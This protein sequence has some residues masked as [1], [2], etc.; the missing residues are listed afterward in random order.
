MGAHFRRGQLGYTIIE[1][2]LFFAVTGA[3]MLGVLGSASFGVNTQRY[4]DAVNTFTAIIQQEFTNVTNVTNARSIESMC[5]PGGANER[6]RGISNCV[7]I[8]RLMTVDTEGDIVSTNIVGSDPG[9]E[10]ETD[11]EIEVIQGYSPKVDVSSQE[12]DKMSWETKLERGNPLAETAASILILRSPRS[13][14]VYSYVIHSDSEIITNDSQL[15]DRISELATASPAVNSVDQYLC[16]DRSGWVVTPAR[17]VRISPFASGP[18]GVA[19]VEVQ[20]TI[21]AG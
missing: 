3:L 11:T 10:D 5:G 12:T 17:A 15:R 6:P 21:C 16:I 20:G 8:G 9:T 2:M 19:N 13:G 7:I 1:V 18:S 4:S 14:N